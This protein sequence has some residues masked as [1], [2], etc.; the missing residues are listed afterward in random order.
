MKCGG[1]SSIR[2]GIIV[3]NNAANRNLSRVIVV[4]LTSN[5]Q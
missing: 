2:P 1:W 4:P 5:T 3:S